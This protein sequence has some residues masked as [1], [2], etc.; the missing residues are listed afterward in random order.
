MLAG[1]S[2]IL[3]FFFPQS[4]WVNVEIAPHLG[5]NYFLLYNIQF[6][7]Y[8]SLYLPM[9]YSLDIDTSQDEK[10]S[11]FVNNCIFFADKSL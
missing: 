8:Y 6:I 11:D 7:I 2:S 5:H 9:L 4:L 1:A 10:N 3:S